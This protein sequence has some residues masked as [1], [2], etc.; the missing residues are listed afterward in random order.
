VLAEQPKEPGCGGDGE[1]NTDDFSC[2]N[3]GS[4]GILPHLNRRPDT[5]I[6]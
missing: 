6:G 4:T 2:N 1:V 5:K 3:P